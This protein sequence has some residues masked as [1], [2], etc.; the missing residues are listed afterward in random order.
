[1]HVDF[2]LVR[3][4]SGFVVAAVELDDRSHR[5]LARRRRDRFLDRVFR[6]AGLALLRFRAV[7]RYDLEAMKDAVLR[8]EPVL[9]VAESDG[10][11]LTR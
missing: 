2:V 4:G 8:A 11:L 6:N 7:R 1:M 5:L 3:P 10:A 9:A